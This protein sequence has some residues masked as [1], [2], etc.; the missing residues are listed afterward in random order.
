MKTIAKFILKHFG[1]LH[2]GY[3]F[4]GTVGNFPLNVATV[5]F[6]YICD[7]FFPYVFALENYT[8]A[9]VKGISVLIV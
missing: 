3:S 5:I 2:K 7:F 4:L 6:F 8:F 1:Y 9:E